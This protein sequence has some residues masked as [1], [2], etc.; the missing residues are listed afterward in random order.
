MAISNEASQ[1]LLFGFSDHSSL[2]SLMCK[3]K[4]YKVSLKNVYLWRRYQCPCNKKL[5][6]VWFWDTTQ[7]AFAGIP[8][9]NF[10]VTFRQKQGG[11]IILSAIHFL[12]V[13]E[14]I[15]CQAHK[16]N[17][18]WGK[19]ETWRHFEGHDMLNKLTKK[20]RH[21]DAKILQVALRALCA[22]SL[23]S[24]PCFCQTL[25]LLACL[26]FSIAVLHLPP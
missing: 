22:T 4:E 14:C 1:N 8:K 25:P 9:I 6:K 3:E 18:F 12:N 26:L 17:F 11:E 16:I 10:S 21:H 7:M 20:K 23:Q 15:K 19:K 5:Q 2:H 24:M 13:L